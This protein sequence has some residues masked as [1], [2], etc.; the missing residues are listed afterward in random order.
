MDDKITQW[1]VGNFGLNRGLKYFVEVTGKV[2]GPQSV[3]MYGCV[4]VRGRR[5]RKSFLMS[6][7]LDSVPHIL[8]VP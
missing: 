2:V 7:K 1:D 5:P 8:P 6:G 3:E 4:H